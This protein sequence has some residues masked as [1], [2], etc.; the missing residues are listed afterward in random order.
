MEKQRCIIFVD[1]ANLFQILKR[2]FGR[3]D[4]VKFRQILSKGCHLV[5]TM[6][7]IGLPHKISREQKKF[8]TYLE[9]N[10]F[11]IRF[12]RVSKNRFGKYHQKGIDILLYSDVV[13]LAQEDS[14]DK[15][16]LVSG[17]A[18]Y[19]KAVEK[20]EELNKKVEIWSFKIAMSKDLLEAAGRRNIRYIDSILDEIEFKSNGK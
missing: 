12:T 19:I 13:E 16:I 14:Y 18:D 17:D 7:Y 8:L 4:Y 10:G 3:I 9:K 1:H 15:A 6:I 11:V 2:F 20:L 5:G